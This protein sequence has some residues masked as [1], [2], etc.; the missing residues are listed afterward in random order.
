M[1]DNAY[2]WRAYDRVAREEDRERISHWN[3]GLDNLA[4]FAG[5]FS[6]VTTAFIIESQHDTQ[7]DYS[8]LTFLVLNA[9]NAGILFKD[10]PFAIDPS[11]RSLPSWARTG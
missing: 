1:A 3:R 5:L 4:L 2:I 11:P 10:E 6:A 9:T 7:P 8:R